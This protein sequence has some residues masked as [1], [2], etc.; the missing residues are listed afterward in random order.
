MRLF[1]AAL[2]LV[3][4]VAYQ[5]VLAQVVAYQG[6]KAP[7]VP[8]QEFESPMILELPFHQAPKMRQG[9]SAAIKGVAEFICEDVSIQTLTVHK[10]KSSKKKGDDYE[11]RGMLYT[12][13]SE[14]RK[15]NLIAEVLVSGTRL[16]VGRQDRIDAEEE[17]HTP[18]IL[19]FRLDPTAVA[20]LEQGASQAIL[21]LTLEVTLAD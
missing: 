2:I 4:L 19:R 6:E 7:P 11:L 16:A 3:F 13:L 20:A 17:E 21:K 15:A 10:Q 8:V 14:D 18:F 9:T 12:R 5:P 1:A